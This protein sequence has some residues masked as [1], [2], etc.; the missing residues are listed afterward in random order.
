MSGKIGKTKSIQSGDSCNKEPEDRH[1]LRQ[2]QPLQ[3]RSDPVRVTGEVNTDNFQ[4]RHVT[5]LPRGNSARTYTK[6]WEPLL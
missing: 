3:G 1:R 5:F 6:W 4:C 2:L